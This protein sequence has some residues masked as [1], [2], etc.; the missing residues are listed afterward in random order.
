MC[1]G[2]L[3]FSC[4]DSWVSESTCQNMWQVLYYYSCLLV[5]RYNQYERIIGLKETRILVVSYYSSGTK[6]QAVL[7]YG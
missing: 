5:H 2:I 4:I 1:F 3:I 7:N 6:R